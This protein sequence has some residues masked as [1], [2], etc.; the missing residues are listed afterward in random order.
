MYIM[1]Y[2][3]IVSDN[4]VRSESSIEA[5]CMFVSWVK[6]YVILSNLKVS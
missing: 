3:C 4:G 2:T 6:V 5:I 1:P